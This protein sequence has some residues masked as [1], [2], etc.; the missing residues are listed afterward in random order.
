MKWLFVVLVVLVLPVVVVVL[1][2]AMLPVSHTGSR[3][4]ALKE[5]PDAVWNLISG[6]PTWRSEIR[7]YEPVGEKTWR[8]IDRHGHAITYEEVSA[9]AP[10]ER[11]TRIADKKLPFGGTWTYE[12]QPSGSGCVLRITENGEVYNVIFRFIS[13][14]F[15]GQTATIDQYLKDVARHFG[16]PAQ[17][18]D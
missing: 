12:I 15:M 6:P 7:G 10:K 18:G 1:W 2:G 9:R 8:E 11:V 4:L 3:S 16:E 17:I 5:S 13:R 14:Y